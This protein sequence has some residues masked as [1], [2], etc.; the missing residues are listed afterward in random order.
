MH[1]ILQ[2]RSCSFLH[3]TW[4][5]L[6]SRFKDDR[7]KAGTIDRYRSSSIHRSWNTRWSF[8]DYSTI[9]K[10]NVPG[11]DGY[12][13]EQPPEHLIY[14]DANNLYGW[15]MSQHLPICGFHWLNCDEIDSFNVNQ[16]GD[17]DDVGYI[18]EVD[19]GK[20]YVSHFSKFSIIIFLMLLLLF[21][22][23]SFIRIS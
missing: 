12:D 8:N 7:C 10:I 22:Y 19:L 15:A 2:T 6:A 16:I 20:T 21:I 1:V 5:V 23:F 13:P 14:W 3:F 18:L 11:E 17:T 4:F 9:C